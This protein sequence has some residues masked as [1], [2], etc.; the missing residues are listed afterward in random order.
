[1]AMVS[2]FLP[3]KKTAGFAGEDT[4]KGLAANIR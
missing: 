4:V 3:I 1:M 2:R